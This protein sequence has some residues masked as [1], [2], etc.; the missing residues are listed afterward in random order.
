MNKPYRF[1]Q[2]PRAM[3]LS[4][5]VAGSLA[6]QGL[7]FAAPQI[8]PN[9]DPEIEKRVTA[10]LVEA[11]AVVEDNYAGSIDYERAV[12]ASIDSMLTTLD[13]HSHFW[14]KEEFT[15]FRNRQASQYSGVGATIVPHNGKIYILAPFENTPALRAGLRYGDHITAIDGQSTQGWNVD[16]V[17]NNL[18]GLRGTPVNVTVERPGVPEPLTF[19]VVRDSVEFPSV[20][21]SFLVKPGIGYIG[22][23]REFQRTTGEEVIASLKDLKAKGAKA[24]L[25]DLRGNPGGLVESARVVVDQ[26][27]GKGQKIFSYKGRGPNGLPVERNFLATNLDPDQSDLV[28]LVNNGSAS[29]SE[30]VSGAIQDHDRGILVG[31]TTFGKGLVQTIYMVPGGYGLT[32]TS[33]KYFTPSGRLIQRNY[34][35]VSKY[36]YEK[37]GFTG[38]GARP[39]GKNNEFQTDSKR[40]VQGGSGIEPDVKVAPTLF[41]LNQIRLLDATF[42]FGRLLVNGQIAGFT[43]YKVEGMTFQHTLNDSEYPASDKLVQA[44]KKFVAEKGND[45]GVTSAMIEENLAFVKQQLRTEVVTAAYG[46]ET[47]T[48]IAIASD[49]Q[50][51]RGIAELPNAHAL[52]EKSRK[53]QPESVSERKVTR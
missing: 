14:N 39:T 3:M 52:L 6:C 29:A 26:F 17:R 13:P 38:T 41:T 42:A 19:R 18:R 46:S 22:L 51:L 28:V 37:Q 9:G 44:F 15:E 12:E 49:A 11:L 34:D 40:I 5:V 31:E 45:F 35:G 8:S 53:A 20:T 21:N 7:T 1:L 4:M 36:D 47:A 30:I 16:K 43:D 27:I 32:L 48:E 50:V 10:S 25:L 24:I 33:A 2:R 23:R